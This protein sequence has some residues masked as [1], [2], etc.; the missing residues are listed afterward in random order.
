MNNYF[1]QEQYFWMIVLEDKNEKDKNNSF[2]K[3]N[4][5]LWTRFEQKLLQKMSSLSFVPPTYKQILTIKDEKNT[6][7]KQ[8]WIIGYIDETNT[9]DFCPNCEKKLF[10]HWTFDFEKIMHH[11]KEWN[12]INYWIF[13]EKAKK[14]ENINCDYHMKNNNYWFNFI[15]SWDDLA[16][17]NIA[18]KWLEY[19]NNLTK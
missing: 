5:S 12:W 3:T 10:W 14:T 9:S 16:T 18:K 7:I 11:Y 19:I 17:Y 8:L 15:K 6:E 13:L 1:L 2:I 4:T